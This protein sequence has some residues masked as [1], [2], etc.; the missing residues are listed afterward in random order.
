MISLFEKLQY[1]D[2]L[3]SDKL[4]LNLEIK[5]PMFLLLPSPRP[6]PE[7]LDDEV[8]ED[9]ETLEALD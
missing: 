9:L 5:Q 3:Q 8:P 4:L 2:L 7:Y 1:K 6:F